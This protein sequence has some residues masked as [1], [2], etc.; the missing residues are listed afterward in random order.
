MHRFE[1]FTQA[2][3]PHEPES[4]EDRLVAVPGRLF[5]VIDGATDLGGL[6]YDDSYGH[7]ATGGYLA[8]QAVADAISRMAAGPLTELPAPEATIKILNQSIASLYARLG[9]KAEEA[10]AGRHRF[11]AGITAAFICESRLRLI[12]IGDCRARVNE[13][14]VLVHD[15]PSDFV[16]SLA[17][18][19]AWRRLEAQGIKAD[20]IRPVARALIVQGLARD[21]VPPQ[22][23]AAVDIEAVRATVLA[24]AEVLAACCGDAARVDAILSAGL[25]GIRADPDRFNASTLDGVSEASCVVRSQDFDLADITTLELASDGYPAPGRTASIVAWEEGLAHA[26]AVDP[27]RISSYRSTKG[28]SGE[29]FGDDRSILIVTSGRH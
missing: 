11:R 9:I 24:D 19:L 1:G 13:K 15:F 8:A 27:E 22:G 25:A 12:A 17:R 4:N 26:D 29:F 7:Q 5:A 6:R 2:K 23:L 3:N 28:R 10:T 18:S 20:A 14:M 16:L 21:R